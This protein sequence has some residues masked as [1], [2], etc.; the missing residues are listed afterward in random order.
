MG[1][2]SVLRQG[3]CSPVHHSPTITF[4]HIKNTWPC[5]PASLQPFYW[6]L[7]LC[8][9]RIPK[10]PR[11]SMEPVLMLSEHKA[12]GIT[13]ILCH[14]AVTRVW[15]ALFPPRHFF[16]HTPLCALRH[17][18]SFCSESCFHVLKQ[19]A[20]GLCVHIS[21][22]LGPHSC[23][24]SLSPHRVLSWAPRAEQHVLTR[25]LFYTW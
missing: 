16:F 19:H 15:K 6:A 22:P 1:L 13:V 14:V 10:Y 20:S 2:S 12:D 17:C 24:T 9:N 3:V 18:I 23:S 4:T 8:G 7:P 5:R 21:S 11:V 25:Y